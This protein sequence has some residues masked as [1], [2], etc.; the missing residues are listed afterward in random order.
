MSLGALSDHI[1]EN[2][3]IVPIGLN[4]FKADMFRSQVTI[5]IGKPFEVPTEWGKQ[6]KDNKREVTE[7]LL[8][9]VESRM[10]AVK[11]CAP[12]IEELRSVLL[13]RKV[14]VPQEVKLSP[15]EESELNKR[16]IKGYQKLKNIPECEQILKEGISYIREI[17]EIGVS[18]KEILNTEFEQKKMKRKFIMSTV[19]FFLSLIFVFPGLIIITPFILYIRNVAE[20][21]R[22]AV[23]HNLIIFLFYLNIG[24]S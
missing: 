14:Y 13:F 1:C 12:T 10:K 24:I 15:T 19:L 20:K 4:Y 18:D 5:E 23:S 9:E 6:F 17:D 7:K 16:F 11:L 2:I 21:E 22:L 3:Q 8:N